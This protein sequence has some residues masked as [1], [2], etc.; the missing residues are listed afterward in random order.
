M[1]LDAKTES[2][3]RIAEYLE[4]NAGEALQAK[5][6]AAGA[7]MAGV[8]KHITEQAR[9]QEQN[10]CACVAD[11]EVFGWAVHY[12]EELGKRTEEEGERTEDGEQR[13]EDEGGEQRTEDGGQR[14][15]DGGQRTEEEEE[16]TEDEGGP[17]TSSFAPGA[18][19]EDN[20]SGQA[21][22]EG[23]DLFGGEA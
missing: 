19:T 10:G 17:S 5:I 1:K 9:K 6:E 13:T 8:M 21:G 16:R 20:G 11:E 2:E 22:F 3:K 18:A 23:L 14:T 7:S 12:Y 4:R 15:E